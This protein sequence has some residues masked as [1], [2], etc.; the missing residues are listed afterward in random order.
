MLFEIYVIYTAITIIFS[1]VALRYPLF[2][3]LVA[4]GLWFIDSQLI[5]G[6]KFVTPIYNGTSGEIEAYTYTYYDADLSYLF[7][8]LG[9]VYLAWFV[10]A[11]VEM[12]LRDIE[13]A[14]KKLPSSL[15]KLDK[16]LGGE[17]FGRKT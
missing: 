5:A 16:L 4:M 11:L 3:S 10:L 2:F 14:E 17:L 12:I 13:E 6:I 15:K 9:I 1:L 7:L 8:L